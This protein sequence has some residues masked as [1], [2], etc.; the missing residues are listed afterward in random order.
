MWEIFHRANPY[1]L[2]NVMAVAVKVVRNDLRPDVSPKC[3]QIIQGT[4]KQC[5]KGAHFSLY[6]ILDI[7]A[8]CWTANPED[9][10]PMKEILHYLREWSA[11]IGLFSQ[12]ALTRS[13]YVVA[14]VCL[15]DSRR[16]PSF[17]KFFAGNSRNQLTLE[18]FP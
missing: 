12:K 6:S 2:E 7:L 3:P 15:T 17:A 4:L 14:T 10:L 9:R 18:H 16:V 1:G 11:E 8:Y 13:T 5:A